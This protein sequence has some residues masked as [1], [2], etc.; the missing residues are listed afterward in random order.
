LCSTVEGKALHRGTL[1]AEPTNDIEKKLVLWSEEL[2]GIKPVSTT[3]NLFTMGGNSLFA[4]KLKN[5]INADFSVCIQL[6]RV[7]MARRRESGKAGL[8]LRHFVV[9]RC[10]CVLMRNAFSCRRTFRLW[11]SSRAKPS[12][13]LPLWSGTRHLQATVSFAL[14]LNVGN[15]AAA[16]YLEM[17][18]IPT[19]FLLRHLRLARCSVKFLARCSFWRGRL[20][21]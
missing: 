8:A 12:A 9:G 20:D 3:A 13:P 21:K 16:A 14:L 10:A 4:V 11:P 18:A 1:L 7:H 15:R 2:L 5:K 6:S 19:L 17:F